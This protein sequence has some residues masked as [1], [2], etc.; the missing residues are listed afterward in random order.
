MLLYDRMSRSVRRFFA[1]VGV[2]IGCL[3]FMAIPMAVLVALFVI[4]T[5]AAFGW[6]S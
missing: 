5:R 1:V 6:W 4:L 3:L 2:T